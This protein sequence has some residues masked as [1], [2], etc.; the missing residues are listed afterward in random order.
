MT[1]FRMCDATNKVL[2]GLGLEYQYELRKDGKGQL[3]RNRFCLEDDTIVLEVL[4]K[5]SEG[6]GSVTINKMGVK[7]DYPSIKL[8]T[9]KLLIINLGRAFELEKPRIDVRV[10]NGFHLLNHIEFNG[11]Y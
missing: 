5:E 10:L 11:V 7:N 3:H 6:V 2:N 4:I 1:K 9:L 8:E